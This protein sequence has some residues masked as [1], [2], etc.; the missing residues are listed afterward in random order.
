MAYSSN[1]YAAD[2]LAITLETLEEA[3]TK[4]ELEHE[5][6]AIQEAYDAVANARS[7]VLEREAPTPTQQ[8]VEALSNRAEER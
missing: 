8:L 5:R 1:D 6:E 7:V 4:S 3:K 2:T